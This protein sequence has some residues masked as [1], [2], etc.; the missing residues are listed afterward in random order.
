ML[1]LNNNPRFMQGFPKTTA[2]NDMTDREL[3]ALAGNTI[4]VP[5]V[6]SIWLCA[7]ALCDFSHGSPAGHVHNMYSEPIVIGHAEDPATDD[8]SCTRTD[9][10]GN[11]WI[12]SLPRDKPPKAKPD[13]PKATAKKAKA[14]AKAR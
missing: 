5:V 3:N 6:G 4:T 9:A 12:H 2:M 13:K 10:L 1:V 14:K 8:E 11:P 7:L